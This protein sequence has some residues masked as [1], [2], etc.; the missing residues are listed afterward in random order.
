MNPD[1]IDRLFEFVDPEDPLFLDYLAK[2]DK[3][4]SAKI[5]M[6]DIERRMT[7]HFHCLWVSI[8]FQIL[9]ILI[10]HSGVLVVA[11]GIMFFLDA[12]SVVRYSNE[13]M[14][15]FESYSKLLLDMTNA[16]MV[17]AKAITQRYQQKYGDNT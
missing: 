7:V 13:Y 8:I 12:K 3:F 6:R 14:N 10:L 2:Y 1:E 17:C 5:Y 15:N 9:A 11:L 4:N 16:Q